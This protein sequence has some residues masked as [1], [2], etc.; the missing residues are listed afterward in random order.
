MEDHVGAGRYGFDRQI[1]QVA[2]DAGD[3]KLG[4]GLWRGSQVEQ[5]EASD[6]A[7]LCQTRGDLAAEEATATK[8]TDL[9]AGT[10]APTGV[11]VHR[12]QMLDPMPFRVFTNP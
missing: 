7:V 1:D 11:P 4:L 3:R 8:D 12:L 9:H 5:R 10:I 2:T 6:A